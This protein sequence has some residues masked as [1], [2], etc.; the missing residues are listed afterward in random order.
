MYE[1]ELGAHNVI[2]MLIDEKAKLIYVGEAEDLIRRFN[3]GH[4]EIKDW[5]FYRYDQL[6]AMPKQQRVALERMFIRAFASVLENKR[7]I[8]TRLISD[9]RLAN[10]KIDF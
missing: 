8:P 1:T 9:Y 5:E 4:S 2:Y 3:A 10:R 7:N 6:P